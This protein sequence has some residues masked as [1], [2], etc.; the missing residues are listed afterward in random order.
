[1]DDGHVAHREMAVKVMDVADD[2]D[3]LVARECVR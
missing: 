1:V 3:A 2:L